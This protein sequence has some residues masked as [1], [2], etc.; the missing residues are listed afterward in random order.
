MTIRGKPLPR[1]EM[2]DASVQFERTAPAAE[3]AAPPAEA[4][5]ARQWLTVLIAVGAVAGLLY[6][7]STRDALGDAWT[8]QV[9]LCVVALLAAL[10]GAIHRYHHW[11]LP[12]RELREQARR[13]QR[14]EVSIESLAG[15]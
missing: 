1:R 10:W 11:T 3:S 7:L 15:L 6:L 5:G 2:T 13:A 4:P 9:M 14:G 8:T 12:L